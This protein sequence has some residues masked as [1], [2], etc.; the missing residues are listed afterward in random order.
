[1]DC[2]LIQ[3]TTCSICLSSNLCTVIFLYTVGTQIPQVEFVEHRYT[4]IYV[5]FIIL[6]CCVPPHLE[7]LLALAAMASGSHQVVIADCFDV[8]QPVVSQCLSRVAY[9]IGSMVQDYIKFPNGNDL[10]KVKEN[11]YVIAGMPG[12]VGCIDCTHIQVIRPPRNDSEVFR[13]RKGYFSLNIQAI[14]GPDLNFSILLQ[15]GQVVC[16]M[17]E[18][19]KT[20]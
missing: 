16:M 2:T 7:V 18:Y 5:F 11:F 17:Q 9:A 12:V 8:L 20:V 3:Q 6:G 4:L 10:Q 1:M 13:C 19:L 14:C 15:G